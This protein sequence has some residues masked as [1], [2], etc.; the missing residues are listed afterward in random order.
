M[1]SN[2]LP[3]S[4]S[5]HLTD[6]Q[7]QALGKQDKDYYLYLLEQEIMF[8]K[9]KRLLYYL[10]NPKQEKFHT[11]PQPIR[12][13]F[14][15][16][17]SGKTTCG[18]VE[19]LWHITGIYPKWYPAASRYN[20]AIKGRIV[21][22]DF[23]K[24]VG[25]VIIPAID[26]WLDYSLLAEKK[27]NPM[28]IPIKWTLKNGS[29]FD[30]LT[31]EQTTNQFE[32]WKGDIVW[33]DEP[34]PRDKYIACLRGLV[35]TGGRAWLTLT[36]LTQPW[37]YDELYVNPDKHRIFSVVM[38]IRDNMH[39]LD[40]TFLDHFAKSLTEE[41]KEARLHGR[42]R[43]LSG[44][45]YKE[46]DPM[47]HIC[48]P[49][50]VQPHWIRYMCIDPH[51]RI[52]TAVIWIAVD[53]KENIWVYDE[54]WLKDMTIDQI[55]HAIHVQEGALKAH[56]RFIDPAMDKDNSKTT[57][58]I[59]IRKELMKYGIYCQRANT[60]KDLGKS[61]IKEALTPMF[62]S[63]H[64]TEVPKMRISRQCPQTIYEFQ[65]YIWGDH[66]RSPEEKDPLEKPL[67]KNDHFMD[68]LR[69]IF[70]SGPRFYTQDEDNEAEEVQYVGEYTKYAKKPVS[71]GSY[72]SLV[73]GP[74]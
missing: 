4:Q 51:P 48:E 7:F 43:H 58:E 73:E 69:Y 34:P 14:G 13:V 53:E 50:K 23:Q 6:E 17:R 66:K 62:S 74:A 55:A 9:S 36:P 32:G 65:H 3:A 8:R 21:A 52:P 30:I 25:E 12:G 67:K 15:A 5:M 27:R 72:R 39:N 70:N 44:L 46:F 38:D 33:F 57:G 45:I 24:G 35:D 59:N 11:A 49:P 26:E 68:C 28:G 42:F 40:A 60:D 10:P 1:N 54:L 18:V 41:E 47:M 31:H 63:L 61:R 22:A 29:V 2:A 64:K 20:R 16:N 19:F 56:Q 71:K 37:I